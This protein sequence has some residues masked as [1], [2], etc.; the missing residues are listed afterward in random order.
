[1]NTPSCKTLTYKYTILNSSSRNTELPC[2]SLLLW[3]D[4]S[5]YILSLF[6]NL[7]F[8]AYFLYNVILQIL[9]SAPPLKGWASE[10][11]SDGR[12]AASLFIPPSCNSI[13][14]FGLLNIR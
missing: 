10:A 3:H 1:M 11:T 9:V 8:I 7:T 2:K 13:K 6:M 5:N 4:L 12:K 14:L